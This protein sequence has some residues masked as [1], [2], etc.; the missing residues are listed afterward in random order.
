VTDGDDGTPIAGATVMQPFTSATA[1]TTDGNGYY[2]LAASTRGGDFGTVV[3]M[4]R[5]GY[6]E[7]HGWSDISE[8]R[9]DFRLYRPLA[10]TAGAA[11][12]VAITADNSMCGFDDEYRCRQIHVAT[13]EAGTLVVESTTDNPADPMWLATG[14]DVEQYPVQTPTSLRIPATAGA[15]VTILTFRPWA[16]PPTDAGTIRTALIPN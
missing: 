3:W 5:S 4:T 9:H 2:D 11:A 14:T 15:T 12:R 16:P 10:V 6:D 7:T 1:V 13:P 8:A